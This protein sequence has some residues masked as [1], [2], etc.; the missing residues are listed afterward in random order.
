MMV[1]ISKNQLV[2]IC[3]ELYINSSYEYELF[4]TNGRI[5]LRGLEKKNLR[6]FL[7]NFKHGSLYKFNKTKNVKKH[8]ETK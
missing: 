7:S 2:M 8:G 4:K 3:F 1:D 5:Q 6:I